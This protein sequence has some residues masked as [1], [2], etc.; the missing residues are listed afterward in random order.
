MFHTE[1]DIGAVFGLGFSPFSGGPFRWVECYVADKL[2]SKMQTFQN[3]YGLPFKTSNSIIVKNRKSQ[4][5]R[6]SFV[7][8]YK[9]FKISKDTLLHRVLKE[10]NN[11]FYSNLTTFNKQMYIN[12]M[13]QMNKIDQQFDK[14]QVL[15]QDTVTNWKY[16]EQNVSHIKRKVTDILAEEYIP[17]IKF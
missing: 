13:N 5:R 4:I 8:H 3:D 11:Q 9:N 10:Q 16:I 15:L 12:A 7:G 1:G 6:E 17:K 14:S 2:V